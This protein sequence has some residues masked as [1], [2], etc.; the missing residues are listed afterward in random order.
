MLFL[1]SKE[2]SNSNFYIV[3]IVKDCVTNLKLLYIV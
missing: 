1:S 2:G 3:I